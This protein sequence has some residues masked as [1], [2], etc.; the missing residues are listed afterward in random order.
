M[1]VK[2][3]MYQCVGTQ[4]ALTSQTDNQIRIVHGLFEQIL[5]LGIEILVPMRTTAPNGFA[6]VGFL[7]IKTAIR[8]IRTHA[9]YC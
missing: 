5:T 2:K 8:A 6:F 3:G 9:I 7:H 4:L 1:L